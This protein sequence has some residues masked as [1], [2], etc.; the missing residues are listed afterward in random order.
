MNTYKLAPTPVLRTL[1]LDGHAECQKCR[2]HVRP[3]MAMTA[4]VRVSN[5]PTATAHCSVC[6]TLND[7]VLEPSG[8]V[9]FAA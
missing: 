8:Q 3:S 9:T 6:S 4:L 7:Y 2:A 1:F 5:V